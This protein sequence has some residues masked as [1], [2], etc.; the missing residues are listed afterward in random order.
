VTNNS[1][2]NTTFGLKLLDLVGLEAEKLRTRY[3][4]THVELM[5]WRLLYQVFSSADEMCV[6]FCAQK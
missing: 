2:L 4:S 1:L 3:S 5:F 6:S